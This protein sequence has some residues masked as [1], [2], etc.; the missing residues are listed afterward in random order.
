MRTTN[1]GIILTALLCGCSSPQDK[2][3]VGVLAQ[4]P[5]EY[6]FV[7]GNGQKAWYSSLELDR[8][9]RSYAAEHKLDFTF[10]GTEKA[11]WVRTD[12]GRVLADVYYSSAI[13]QPILHVAI[14]HHGKVISQDIGTAVCG[15]GAK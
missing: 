13:G 9:A 7:A 15:T 10:E 3:K 8:I 2:G 6:M 1:T 12:G 5:H 11:V 14:D 4:D